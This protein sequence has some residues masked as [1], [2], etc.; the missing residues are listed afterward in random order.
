[1]I[2]ATDASARRP[3]SS[4]A[5]GGDQ[6][7]LVV[8]GKDPMR[9]DKDRDRGAH[10]KGANTILP[11]HPRL[12]IVFEMNGGLGSADFGESDAPCNLDI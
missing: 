7:S 10:I 2:R 8:K 9:L 12:A 5:D 3:G 6:G 11:R 4:V 1:V